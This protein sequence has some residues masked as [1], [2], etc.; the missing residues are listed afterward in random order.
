MNELQIALR[1]L[2]SDSNRSEVL[3]LPFAYPGNKFE[4]LKHILPHLPQTEKYC[5]PTGGSAAVLINRHPSKLE[6]YNDR[7]GGICCF[8]RVLR[9]PTKTLD[10]LKRL[11][12]MS[13]HSREE[14]TW[15]KATWKN[16]DDEIERAARWYY[17]IR[18]SVKCKPNG[19]FGR[20]KSAKCTFADRL[21][22]SIPLM[23]PIATRMRT[24]TIENLDWRTC[25]NDYNQPGMVWY[26]DFEYIDSDPAYEDKMTINDH[27]ELIERVPGL[28]GFVAV[29][30][31]DTPKTNEIYDKAGLWTDKVT[32]KRMTTADTLAATDSNH[33]KN[34]PTTNDRS[35]VTEVLWIRDKL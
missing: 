25:C 23:Y 13:L 8:F 20:S 2:T 10:F 29:S 4:Q 33:Q 15:C 28:D 12:A 30:S 34:R 27:K 3:R 22:K 14:F 18:F 26:F 6:I 7:Y 5:E 1:G 24:T 32:W 35:H 11:A 21:I 31:Y 9:D 19:T 17:M 16:C